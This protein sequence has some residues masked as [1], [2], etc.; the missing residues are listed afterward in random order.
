MVTSAL[1]VCAVLGSLTLLALWR[2]AKLRRVTRQRA[3]LRSDRIAKAAIPR[4]PAQAPETA[5]DDD[6]AGDARSATNVVPLSRPR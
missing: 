2:L 5:P 1:V 6:T 4:A 3:A